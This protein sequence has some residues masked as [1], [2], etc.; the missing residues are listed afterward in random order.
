MGNLSLPLAMTARRV[1]GADMQRA[2]I[3][4]ARR[5]AEDNGLDNTE[6][7]RADGLAALEAMAGEP[8]DLLVLDPPRRGCR[9]VVEA[10]PAR[11]F[12]RL[13]YVSCDPA[14]LGRDL[15]LLAAKGYRVE[16]ITGFDMF[17]QTHH[18]EC[19]ALLAR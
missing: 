9:E 18:V 5:N 17:P 8:F 3:R 19:M 12:A 7:I 15:A 6:F 14:T 13:L 4:A 1:V 16:K 11:G 2:A 10:L